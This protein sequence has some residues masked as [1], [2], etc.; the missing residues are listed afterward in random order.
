MKVVQIEISNEEHAILVRRARQAGKSL[1]EILRSLILSY[2]SSGN[3]NPDDS[4]F[5]LRFEGKNGEHGSMKHDT[6]LYGPD[7]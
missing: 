3:V 7:D 6:I 4:F 2:L 1:E 5:D